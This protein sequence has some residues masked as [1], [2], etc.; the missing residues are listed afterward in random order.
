MGYTRSSKELSDY[1]KRIQGLEG[2]LF[3]QRAL[4]EAEREGP[5]SKDVLN[6]LP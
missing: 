4:H 2:V 1:M 6:M 5:L 3:Y